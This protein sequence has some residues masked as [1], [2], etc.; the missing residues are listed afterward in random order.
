MTHIVVHTV[1]IITRRAVHAGIKLHALIYGCNK[2]IPHV[3]SGC[4]GTHAQVYIFRVALRANYKYSWR[5]ICITCNPCKLTWFLKFFEDTNPFCRCHSQG[6]SPHLCTLLPLL[7]GSLIFTSE[8]DTCQ[9]LGAVNMTAAQVPTYFFQVEV[10]G[11]HWDLNWGTLWL[12]HL[13]PKQ[14]QINSVPFIWIDSCTKLLT[15][16]ASLSH[17]VVCA[18]TEKSANQIQARSIV[19]TRTLCTFINIWKQTV[20]NLMHVFFLLP[21][22]RRYERNFTFHST[23]L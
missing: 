10:E 7:N 3:T 8:C 15:T 9:H 11:R 6:G 17:E 16:F 13:D 21:L 22:R 1:R 14:P 19:H 5:L 4:W 2:N 12:L 18:I 23:Q 20:S